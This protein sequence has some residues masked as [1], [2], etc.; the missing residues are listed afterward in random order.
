MKSRYSLVIKG[1]RADAA[2]ALRRRGILDFL[3]HEA[4]ILRGEVTASVMANAVTLATWFAEDF[5]VSDDGEFPAGSL[6]FFTA[7]GIR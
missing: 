3:F 5:R 1:T 2:T 6:L 7:T 4:H